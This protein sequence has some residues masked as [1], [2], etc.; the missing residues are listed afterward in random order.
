MIE[1]DNYDHNGIGESRKY[2][3]PKEIKKIN[4]SYDGGRVSVFIN[5]IEIYQSNCAGN[6][7]SINIG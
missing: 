4:F 7:F 6:D 1:L 5:D 3:L 2:N